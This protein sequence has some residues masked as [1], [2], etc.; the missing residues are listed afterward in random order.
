MNKVLLSIIKAGIISLPLSVLWCF[1]NIF[2]L[3][4]IRWELMPYTYVGCFITS[5]IVYLLFYRT[6][7]KLMFSDKV[8]E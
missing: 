8:S 4:S 3:N 7:P 2:D 1:K 6:S 5:L